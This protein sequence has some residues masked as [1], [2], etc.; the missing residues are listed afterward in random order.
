MKHLALILI[1]A[2]LPILSYS[3]R[4]QRPG[5]TTQPA[6][7]EGREQRPP[8]TTAPAPAPKKSGTATKTPGAAGTVV[9]G[10]EQEITGYIVALEDVLMG[11]ARKLTPE[12]AQSALKSKKPM[13]LM[14]GDNVYIVINKDFTLAADRMVAKAKDEQMIVKGE[15]FDKGG[16]KF[17]RATDF[18]SPKTTK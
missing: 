18:T 16:M 15:L 9:K 6:P 3:Q 1:I 2:L 10:M 5:T 4:E 12:E 14:S 7:T 8:S 17:I 11:K 13:G